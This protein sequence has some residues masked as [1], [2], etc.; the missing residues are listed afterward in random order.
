MAAGRGQREAC[1]PGGTVQG[2]AFGGAKIC[3]SEKWPSGKLTFAL[4]EQVS[5][6]MQQLMQLRDEMATKL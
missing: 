4:Q 3:N 1:T 2:A 5:S 6:I